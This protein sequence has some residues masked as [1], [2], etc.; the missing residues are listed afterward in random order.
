MQAFF[1]FTATSMEMA[2][3]GCSNAVEILLL[4]SL[5]GLTKKGG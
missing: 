4:R 3:T 2:G 5:V 1:V